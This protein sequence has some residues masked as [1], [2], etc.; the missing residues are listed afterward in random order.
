[1]LHNFC[2]PIWYFL[3]CHK[4]KS[5]ENDPIL[6]NICKIAVLVSVEKSRVREDTLRLN[7]FHDTTLAFLTQKGLSIKAQC[8]HKSLSLRFWN[9]F[10]YHLSSLS[11]PWT[12]TWKH[13]WIIFLHVS[14]PVAFPWRRS[15]ASLWL[16]LAAHIQT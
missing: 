12:A 9:V 1:M 7:L 10:L 15:R 16:A 2:K 13:L 8:C 3:I 5:N 11:S 6:P 4:S 14:S